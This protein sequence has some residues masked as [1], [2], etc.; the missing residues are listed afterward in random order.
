MKI[1]NIPYPKLL[2]LI[3][4]MLVISFLP[5]SIIFYG[6][7]AALVLLPLILAMSLLKNNKSVSSLILLF[8]AFG[9][10]AALVAPPMLLLLF[11]LFMIP[12]N[13]LLLVWPSIINLLVAYWLAAVNGKR[14]LIQYSLFVVFS[15]L[16][17]FNA[18]IPAMVADA[19]SGPSEVLETTRLLKVSAKTGLTVEGSSIP[20]RYLEKPFGVLGLR[21]SEGCMCYTWETPRVVEEDLARDLNRI[22]L[23]VDNALEIDKPRLSINIENKSGVTYATYTLQDQDGI[24]ASLMLRKRVKYLLE[25]DYSSEKL[26]LDSPYARFLYLAHS[27]FWNL[28]VNNFYKQRAFTTQSLTPVQSFINDHVK[29]ESGQSNDNYYVRMMPIMSELISAGHQSISFNK[30]D[31]TLEKVS[32]CEVQSNQNIETY[33][34]KP[35]YSLSVSPIYTAYYAGH[36]KY[37]GRQMTFEHDHVRVTLS[38]NWPNYGITG[39]I[40]C[41]EETYK[42]IEKLP[43]KDFFFIQEYSDEGSLLAYYRVK[44]PPNLFVRGSRLNFEWIGSSKDAYEFAVTDLDKNKTYRFLAYKTKFN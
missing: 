18:R 15:F 42:V 39:L 10:I 35:G 25:P 38:P 8:V 14:G 34:L 11:L 32:K 4:A 37:Y 1:S 16:L 44:F 26:E 19:L 27:N 7:M 40:F 33:I 20:L 9:V 21:G 41:S 43:S 2:L 5:A 17:G 28:L 22:P 3:L 13:L 31:S 29:V 23:K 36:M 6:A 30:T 12:F 24:A